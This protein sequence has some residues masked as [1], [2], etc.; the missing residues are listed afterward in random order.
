VGVAVPFLR[1]LRGTL[2]VVGKSPDGDSIRFIPAKPD[3]LGDL[4]RGDRVR[5]SRVDGSVQLRLEGIDAPETHYGRDAQPEGDA[6]RDWLLD[7]LGFRD[8]VFSRSGTVESA[9]P[10]TI[11]ATILSKGVDP[12][13]RPI[14]Y[15]LTGDDGDGLRDGAWVELETALLDRTAN[16]RSLAA[17]L[18]YLTLY[19]STP[20]PHR[21]RL[22]KI[23]SGARDAGKGV[24]AADETAMFRLADQASIS[25]PNGA[26]ILP[27]LF[28]R[29][30]DYLK[31]RAD[32]FRGTLPDWLVSVSASGSRPEDD[33][34]LVGGQAEVPLSTLV[35][36]LNDR[37]GFTPDLLD[38]VFVEK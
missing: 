32:G 23:A 17:G 15:L 34:V 12:N 37:I 3:L 26:L 21:T 30:T 11:A 19:T 10:P 31:D 7:R 18:S 28:R 16:A 6:A 20:A 4:Y 38:I 22:R 24:W 13:G 33:H 1:V 5:A 29:C 27:K 9:T 8:V 14:A 2:T 35:K 25:P 36:Q